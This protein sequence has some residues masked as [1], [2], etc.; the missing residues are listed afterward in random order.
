MR[1]PRNRCRLENHQGPW[2]EDNLVA[3]VRCNT[4]FQHGTSGSY[5]HEQVRAETG[6][7]TRT[8]VSINNGPTVAVS[9]VFWVE[10]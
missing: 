2:G 1:H 3:P 10:Y 7:A 4:S 9:A 6:L 8:P 5:L